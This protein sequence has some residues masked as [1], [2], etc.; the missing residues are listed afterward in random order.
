MAV[1]AGLVT[2]LGFAVRYGED[3]QVG[4]SNEVS[5]WVF[6]VAGVLAYWSVLG[7]AVSLYKALVRPRRKE[8]RQDA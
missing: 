7:F 4:S 2:G 6:V 3:N 8:P 1:V 5:W